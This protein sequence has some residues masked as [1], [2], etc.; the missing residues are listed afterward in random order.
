[1]LSKD[2]QKLF[3]M[4]KDKQQLVLEVIMVGNLK[5]KISLI[6]ALKM[7][8]VITSQN[9]EHLNRI[10]QLRGKIDAKSKWLEP[11]SMIAPFQNHFELMQL[12]LL[13]MS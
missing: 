8:L 6:I 3:K 9:L 10:K 5:M 12:I 13:I 4:K 2:L 11:C 7:E 1:M